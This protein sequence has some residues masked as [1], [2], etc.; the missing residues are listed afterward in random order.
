[1]EEISNGQAL[2]YVLIHIFQTNS[3]YE[4]LRIDF[5]TFSSFVSR[6]Q[7]GYKD[8]PYHNKLHAFDVT[9]SICF[10]LKKCKFQELAALSDLETASMY[11]SAAIH[12]YE[13]PFKLL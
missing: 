6:I 10:F 5:S 11:L 2:S 12:D 1:M 4:K 13:H 9:Q 3:F 7:N 8:N